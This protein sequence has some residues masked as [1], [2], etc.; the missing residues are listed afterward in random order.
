MPC[1]ERFAGA[2]NYS[3]FVSFLPFSTI[4]VTTIAVTTIAVT[5]CADRWGE[6]DT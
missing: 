1:R 4:A 6:E 5:T 3:I 2:P